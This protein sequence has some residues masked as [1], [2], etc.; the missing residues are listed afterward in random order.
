MKSNSINFAIRMINN[1]D[2]ES[3]YTQ[4]RPSLWRESLTESKGQMASLLD[5]VNIHRGRDRQEIFLFG[6]AN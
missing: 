4:E 6:I 3:Q 5:D 1:T 2:A